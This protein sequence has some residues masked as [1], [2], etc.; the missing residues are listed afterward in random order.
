AAAR[1]PAQTPTAAPGADLRAARRREGAARRCPRHR[2]YEP[3]PGVRGRGWTLSPRPLRAAELRAGARASVARAARGPAAPHAPRTRPGRGRALDRAR[4]RG[5]ARSRWARLRVAGERTPPRAARGAALDAGGLG[6]GRRAGA[7]GP[8][9]PRARCSAFRRRGARPLVRAAVAPL[10]CRARLARAGAPDLS[11]PH[12]R[13]AGRPSQD[14]RVGALQ[15]AAPVR[16]R[17]RLTD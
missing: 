7:P 9:R 10:G 15:E 1:A 14:Q 6:A 12:A 3:R 11:R 2:S 8:H 4:A 16:A 13:R 17:E 5:G